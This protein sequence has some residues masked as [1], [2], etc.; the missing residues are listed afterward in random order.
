MTNFVKLT[1]D[2]L[3]R[4]NEVT[5]DPQG[6]GFDDVRGVQALAKNA[7]NNSI[8]EILQV[9]QEWPFL[10]T[11]YT[12]VLT[13]GQ[14]TYDFPTSY[15]SADYESFYL[16]RV[17][18]LDNNPAY[19][20]AISYEDY[21]QNHRALDDTGPADGRSAPNKVFQTYDEAFGV[22][23][24]PDKAYEVEYTY[25]SFP[26]D[27]ELYNDKCVIPGRFNYVIVDGAM[28]YMMRFRS[29]EQSA[30]VHQQKFEDGIRQMRRVLMDEPL[31]IRSTVINKVAVNG[32]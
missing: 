20:D 14:T 1:N 21:V 18:A 11:T 4:L 15:S 19:L 23:P 17:A 24:S 12:Q 6:D 5:L 7:I 9:G 29:N 22:T 32:R 27:L 2:L 28:M 31:E 16:K 25:W 10:K 3:T 8:R 13:P 30:A 26:D